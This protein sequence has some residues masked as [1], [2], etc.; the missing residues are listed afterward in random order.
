MISLKKQQIKNAIPRV[1]AGLE[2]YLWLQKEFK[3]RDVIKDREFQRKF[4]GFYKVRRNSD[5]Q[6]VFY[7]L[8]ENNKNRK[9][10]FKDTLAKLYKKTGRMEA[11]FA[12]KLVATINPK[13]PV[14]DAVV[15][16]NLGLV[17]P[18]RNTKNRE[19]LIDERYQ[20]LIKEFSLFLQ[21][22]EGKYLIGKF[23]KEYPRANI[24]EIKMLDFILWQTRD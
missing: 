6:K 4:N 13:M 15:F 2:K 14:I 18:S 12:S 17:L 9:V 24:T 21:T 22:E 20:H 8:L 16:K 5:W 11:S 10:S 1:K 19:L 7:E 3:L 23:I